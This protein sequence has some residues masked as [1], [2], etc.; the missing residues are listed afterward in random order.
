MWMVAARCGQDVDNIGAAEPSPQR[1][2][3]GGVGRIENAGR[4]S[5]DSGAEPQANWSALGL[6]AIYDGLWA[7]WG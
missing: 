4:R 5:A 6:S 1:E 7:V 2:E 3:V